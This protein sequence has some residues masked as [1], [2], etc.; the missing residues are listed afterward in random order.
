MSGRGA[1]LVVGIAG[2][3][4]T[5]MLSV[6]TEA[7]EQAGY[8]VIG[9]AT[10]GQAAHT[11]GREASIGES[12]TLASLAWR[13]GHGQLALSE[14]S[15]LI[16]DEVG[17]TDDAELIRLAGYIEAA[18][19]KLVLVGDDR[20]LGPV[21]PGG[22][23]GALVG[24]HPGAVRY[25]SENRRQTDPGERQALQHLRGGQIARSLSWYV[26]YQRIHP[27]DDR[28]DALAAAVDA[29]ATDVAA[30]HDSGQYAW[31]RANVAELNT[32]AR[33]WMTDTGRL[34]GPELAC[35]GGMALRAGDDLIALAP[36]HDAGLVT[37]QRVTVESVDPSAASLTLRCTD[38]RTVLLPASEAGANQVDY[39]Y[40]TTVHRAQG[41][42]V[43]RAHLFADGGG[44][45]LAYVAMSRARTA[46]HA[47]V[48]ADDV[49]QAIDDLRVD[50]STEKRPVWAIDTGLPDPNHAERDD[51][52]ILPDHQ[53]ARIVA[54]AAAQYRLTADQVTGIRA[55]DLQAAIEDVRAVVEQSSQARADLAV[56]AGVYH[57][58]DAGRAVRDLHQARARHQ[59]AAHAAEHAD[60]RRD[61]RSAAKQADTE[62]A[63]QADAQ[64]R[65]DTYV[66]PEAARLGNRIDR[67]RDA[68]DQLNRRQ[69]AFKQA[70]RK[71]RAH[72]VR[73]GQAAHQLGTQLDNRYRANLDG[74][75]PLSATRGPRQLSHPV[76]S[77][78]PA[79]LA[80]RS[81][82]DL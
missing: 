26:E 6:V 43:D 20:Q 77:P 24:R 9:T 81:A 36:N 69:D 50:W 18:G 58:T 71:V 28:Q 17:M 65:F 23:L 70:E 41:A 52:T 73:A 7:F 68:L 49:G 53:K 3:G 4:K 62:A 82:P 31:R 38:G 27:L 64:R 33:Q 14:R 42:T 67:H 79:E 25:L 5:T 37:S 57:G 46:T 66:T 59:E 40:A 22:A 29:W 39:G 80:R 15:V 78:P 55:P 72:G 63:E 2:S 76:A 35:G 12:R 74:V 54:L 16:L 61:R 34:T 75:P 44:R 13:L 56:G 11:L 48:V 51:L 47:W 30:G 8:Q 60:R 10:S 1:E 21:G 19:A 32:R 45:E